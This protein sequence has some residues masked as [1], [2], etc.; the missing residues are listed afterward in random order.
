MVPLN[1]DEL[2][3]RDPVLGLTI[4]KLTNLQAVL[5]WAPNLGAIDSVPMDEY[6]Y[7]ITVALPD[8][9]WVVFG[10]T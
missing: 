7:D 6:N 2:M 8:G 10:V 9:R 4:S 5:E 1:L 3:P